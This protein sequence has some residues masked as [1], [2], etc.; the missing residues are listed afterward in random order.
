MNEVIIGKTVAMDFT[1][2]RCKRGTLSLNVPR[3]RNGRFSTELFIHY[4]RSEQA[5]MLSL[6]E[7]VVQG[8]S[9]RKVSAI[10]EE[11]CGAEFSKST[12]SDLCRR[13]DPLVEA[14]NDRPLKDTKYPFIRYLNI[15][16]YWQWRAENSTP[17]TKVVRLK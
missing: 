14:W 10:T 6:M 4:Q 11:L 5:L 9:T 17:S 8:V 16:G 3:L 2:V 13:I 7:I 12:V 15:D 1:L